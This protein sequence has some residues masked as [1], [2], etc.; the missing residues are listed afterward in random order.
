[1]EVPIRII[2]KF[3]RRKVNV[4]YIIAMN[5][6]DKL[7]RQRSPSMQVNFGHETWRNCSHAFLPLEGYGKSQHFGKPRM[8]DQKL[9]TVFTEWKTCVQLTLKNQSHNNFLGKRENSRWVSVTLV[10]PTD[11]N[12]GLPAIISYLQTKRWL[13]ILKKEKQLEIITWLESTIL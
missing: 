4:Q 6:C 9:K 5:R 2:S 10:K 13:G 12:S 11:L 8:V 3:P 1:M 7:S